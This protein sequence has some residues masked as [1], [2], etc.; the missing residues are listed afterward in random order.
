MCGRKA[1]LKWARI[2]VKF[3]GINLPVTIDIVIDDLIFSMP[4]CVETCSWVKK[5]DRNAIEYHWN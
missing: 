2:C 5:F 3:S 1:S 4:L